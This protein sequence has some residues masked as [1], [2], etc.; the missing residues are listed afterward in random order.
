MHERQSQG[1]LNFTVELQGS[2]IV[3]HER[4]MLEVD[5]HLSCLGN[6]TIGLEALAVDTTPGC[7]TFPDNIIGLVMPL[8][9]PSLQ[10]YIS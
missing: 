6:K 9:G 5:L 8:H 1:F 7:G 2:G 4:L 3:R 10:A